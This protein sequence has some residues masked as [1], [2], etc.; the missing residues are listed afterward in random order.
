M[1]RQVRD[2][3]TPTPSLEGFHMCSFFLPKKPHDLPKVMHLLLAGW[4]QERLFLPLRSIFTSLFAF[5]LF[6]SLV[7]TLPL[8]VFS[9]Y[10]HLT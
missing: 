6:K 4:G 5:E 7:N 1:V 2:Q 9:L 8:S 10:F 3:T